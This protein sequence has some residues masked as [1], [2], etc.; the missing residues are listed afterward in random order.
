MCTLY[1]F[2][3]IVEK[4]VHLHFQFVWTIRD[5]ELQCQAIEEM[6]RVLSSTGAHGSNVQIFKDDQLSSAAN[7]VPN[8]PSF[9]GV[10]AAKLFKP[11]TLPR[12]SKKLYTDLVVVEKNFISGGQSKRDKI[13]VW[14]GLDKLS[15]YF[16]GGLVLSDDLKHQF[17]LTVEQWGAKFLQ[18]FGETHIT[19][20]IVSP[21]FSIYLYLFN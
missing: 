10:H 12:G 15:P 16:K 8:K 11:S 3:R 7:S 21:Q 19:H 4:I 1:C 2:N 13:D 6:Q 14:E 20:Y 18:A 5:K 17:R 9:N